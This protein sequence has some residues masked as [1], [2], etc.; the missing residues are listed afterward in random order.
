MVALEAAMMAA[1]LAVPD[2]VGTQRPLCSRDSAAA[3]QSGLS[4]RSAVG[5]Q[6]PLCSR[7]SAAALQSELSSRCAVVRRSA[8]ALCSGCVMTR[9]LLLCG[10]R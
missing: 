7:D 5:T 10:Q 9:L 8:V 3:L 6:Q 1:L 4:S 2:S